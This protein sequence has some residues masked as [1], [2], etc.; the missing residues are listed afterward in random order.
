MKKMIGI[1]TLVIVFFMAVG[2]SILGTVET[3]FGQRALTKATLI[4]PP[5]GTTL[6]DAKWDAR[7]VNL[8]S[9]VCDA[10]DISSTSDESRYVKVI[11]DGSAQLPHG[12]ASLT[13]ITTD[14][15]TSVEAH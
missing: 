5:L 6:F 12:L 11:L 8:S 9:K 15:M 13:M 10:Q 7:V 4:S 14:G 1:G 3:A 2:I